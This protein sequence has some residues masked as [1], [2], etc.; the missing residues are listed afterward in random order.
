M[1]KGSGNEALRPY[2][3]EALALAR[4]RAGRHKG[5]CEILVGQ[6]EDV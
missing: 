3:I 2:P 4:Y 1:R 5:A 6:K